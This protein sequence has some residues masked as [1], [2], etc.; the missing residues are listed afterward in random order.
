L[1]R[2]GDLLGKEEMPDY[3]ELSVEKFIFRVATDRLYDEQGLWV[4]PEGER[5]RIGLSDFL[6]QRSGDIAFAEVKPTGT[7]LSRG[8]EVASIETIK[9]N[10]GVGSPL[11]GRVVEANGLLESEPEQ[12]NA[13]PYGEGWL[14]VVEAGAW[15]EEQA[16]LLEPG[17]F[18][19]LMEAQAREELEAE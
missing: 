9:V 14:A 6:Q 10:L 17:E 2:A 11:S 5:V 8:D 19:E 1:E 15:E 4:L 12:I 13:D 18:L 7:V 3:A 16:L